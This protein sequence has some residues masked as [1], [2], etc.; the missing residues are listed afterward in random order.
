MTKSARHVDCCVW[1]I[2]KYTTLW[3]KQINS[4]LKVFSFD[5]RFVYTF[6]KE[7]NSEHWFSLILVFSSSHLIS[8]W[9]VRY[10]C[11]NRHRHMFAEN[12]IWLKISETFRQSD[13]DW[14]HRS[15]KFSISITYPTSK[16]NRKNYRPFE[17]PNHT[18][19][20]LIQ[21]AFITIE[22]WM[23]SACAR[24]VYTNC[25]ASIDNGFLSGQMYM[26][27]W[28]QFTCIV[29]QCRPCRSAHPIE[30]GRK[31]HQFDDK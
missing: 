6:L 24:I 21:N 10:S 11:T 12:I 4:R 18:T 14:I 27:R 25:H 1:R 19:T 15:V 22:L 7:E 31:I 30:S 26:Q 3:K 17:T 5:F 23:G 29:H 20:Q 9:R 13:L 2:N 28:S 8:D 16:S